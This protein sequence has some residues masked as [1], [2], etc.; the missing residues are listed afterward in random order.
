MYSDS[1]LTVVFAPKVSFLHSCVNVAL[2]VG[3]S[4]ELK[5]AMKFGVFLPPAAEGGKVPV[6]YWLSGE[7]YSLP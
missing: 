5:C 2:G 6:L 7:L 1:N 4:T 3:C